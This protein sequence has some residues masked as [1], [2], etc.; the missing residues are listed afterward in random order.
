MNFCFGTMSKNSVDEIIRFSL[1]NPEKEII[2]IPSRRQ[3]E[4]NGG[5]VNNWTTQS[6]VEYIKS[7]NSNIKI[8]RDHGGPGQ[9]YEMDDGYMSL[10]HDCKYMDIIH[11]D[12]WKKYNNINEGIQWT[13]DMIKYCNTQNPN[14]LYEIATE[15]SIRPFTIE[16]LELLITTLQSELNI[17]LFKKIKFLVIQCG[18]KLNECKNIGIFDESKLINMISLCNKYGLIAK[19][20]NGDWTSMDIINQKYALGL[21]YINIAPEIAEIETLTILNKLKLNDD[22]NLE[23][24]YKIC[25]DSNRWK[26]WVCND[27][28]YINKKDKIIQISCHYIY[29][30][31]LFIQIKNKIIDIDNLI[32][33]NINKKLGELTGIYSERT[34]C[35]FCGLN[36]FELVLD[37]DLKTTISLR[38]TPNI[39]ETNF[40]PYNILLCNNCN[41]SQNK[42]LG[43]L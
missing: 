29:T 31:P 36:D 6:F 34:K 13:I 42:Y 43:N 40:M 8:E 32:K 15:E 5:Y 26:K 33:E 38:L 12:P 27:F 4:Y 14:L 19:E 7:Y 24:L 39:Q 16:E 20:H 21:K 2:F 35:I 28:D 22:D 9:G 10:F 1:I 23:K 3:I 41:T 11:I 37:K 18:T 17:E 30:D 25:L